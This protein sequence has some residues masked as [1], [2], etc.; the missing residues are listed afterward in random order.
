MLRWL[1]VS[2]PDRVTLEFDREFYN[3]G[4]EVEVTARVLDEQYEADN[5]ATLWIQTTN[6]LEKSPIPP[7]N[8]ISRKTGVYRTSFTAD[9]EGVFNLLVD[10]TSAAGEEGSEKQAAI[11][12]TPSLREFNNA[13]MDRGLLARMAEAAGGSYF[14]LDE[15]DAL[16]ESIEFT[17]N[18]YSREVQFDLWDEPWLLALLISL[19]CLDWMTRR[20]RGLS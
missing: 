11:V 15:L 19:L 9:Q 6:P 1:A 7:W 17:P 4:D 20:L 12:V 14:D 5:D 3:I 2:A 13:G 8:G 10:V 16:P 18:A